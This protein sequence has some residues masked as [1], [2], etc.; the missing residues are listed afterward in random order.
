MPHG[1]L[2][3]WENDSRSTRSPQRETSRT[4]QQKHQKREFH[5]KEDGYTTTDNAR[6][7][8]QFLTNLVDKYKTLDAVEFDSFLAQNNIVLHLGE[9]A[10]GWD[11]A[12]K[13]IDLLLDVFESK[14]KNDIDLGYQ[15][16][17]ESLVG[18]HFCVDAKMECL[19]T[20]L[21]AESE[22]EQGKPIDQVLGSVINRVIQE[23]C[24]RAKL[25][26]GSLNLSN[27]RGGLSLERV[28]VFVMRDKNIQKAMSDKIVTMKDID[29]YF[30]EYKEYMAFSEIDSQ[31]LSCDGLYEKLHKKESNR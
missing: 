27:Y 11:T 26:R 25:A 4:I 17:Q 22:F 16:F 24:D 8:I 29:Q 10:S 6:N 7:I 2:Q 3:K 9:R 1:A 30:A 5:R 19:S 18:S 23:M 21:F 12:V 14:Y 20:F 28:K 31:I 13:H 15:K